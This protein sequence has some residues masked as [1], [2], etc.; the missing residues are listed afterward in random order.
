MT[1]TAAAPAVTAPPAPSIS[2]NA[3][4]AIAGTA[5]VSD[6]E[7]YATA[8]RLAAK[9]IPTDRIAA[10]MEEAG[11]PGWQP[12]QRTAE[13]RRHDKDFGVDPAAAART[14]YSFPLSPTL[15]DAPIDQVTAI[16]GGAMSLASDLGFDL[17]NG[18]RFCRALVDTSAD[19]RRM[20]PEQIAETSTRWHEQLQEIYGDKLPSVAAAI[21]AMVKQNDSVLA[22]HLTRNGVLSSELRNPRLFVWLANRAAARQLWK[23]TRPA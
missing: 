9:G 12:D 20:S 5:T 14:T 17:N 21:E 13:Q 7:L 16:N 6:N 18:A 10:I 15:A 22:K 8:A 11:H 23:E 3:Q 4:P 2:A 19:I 1:D